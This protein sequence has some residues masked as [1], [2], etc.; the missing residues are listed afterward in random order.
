LTIGVDTLL[1]QVFPIMPLHRLDEEPTV[2]ATLADLTCDSDGHLTDF[3]LTDKT[4]PADKTSKTLLLHEIP[5]S[6]ESMRVG[7]AEELDTYV[8]GMFLGGA[9]QVRNGPNCKL[10]DNRKLAGT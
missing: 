4:A 7:G 5:V 2:R 1:V 8:M 6:S 3:V 9:Y 10:A